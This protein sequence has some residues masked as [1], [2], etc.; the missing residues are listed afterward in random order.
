LAEPVSYRLPRTAVPE[1]YELTLSPDLASASFEGSARIRVRVHEP[2]TELV[3]NAIELDILEAAVVDSSGRRAEGRLTFDE[4]E[5]RV[6]VTTGQT[7]DPGLYDLEFRFNGILNDKLRGFYRST[8]K[9]EDGVEQVIATTQFEAT[10]ARRAFPCW[11]EPDFKATFAVTLVVDNSLTALSN[12]AIVKEEDAGG[13]KRRV[14]FAET[15]PMSTYLVAFVVGPFECTDPVE[16]D[17]VPLRVAA[18]PGH[19]RLTGFALEAGEAALRFLAGYFELPYPSDKLDH[20]AIPDFA[21]GAMEN[22]GCVTYRSTALL[23]DTEESSRLELQR[24]AVVVAHETAHMWFGDLVTMKW[25]NGIWLNEAFATLMEVLTTDHFRPEWQVWTSFGL[26][27]NAALAVDGLSSTRPI[28]FPVRQPK[29]AD[30]MFDV[31]TYQKGGAVLRMLEQH[32]GPDT[33]RR[34]IARYL[35]EH[36]YGNTETT[37]LWDA[38][39][40]VSGDPVRSTMDS[41]IFQG[42]YPLISVAAEEG[43]RRLRL[44]QERFLY[45]GGSSDER[46]QVP[47]G[48]RVSAGGKIEH[49][50]LLLT[51]EAASV[52]L[53]GPLD[54]V[55]ANDGA[56]GFYRTRYETALL[57]KLTHPLREHLDPLERVS[58]I[59]DTWAAVLSGHSDLADYLGLIKLLGDEEDPDV[60]AT[61]FG[62]LHLLDRIIGD[63]DRGLLETFV[64]RVVSPAFTGVGWDPVA[65]EADRTRTLR[66]R[67]IHALGTLGADPEVRAEAAR[68]HRAYLKDHH[69]LAPDLVSTAAMVVTRA[70]GEAE[71]EVMVGQFRNAATPQEEIRYLYTLGA[72]EEPE[73]IARTLE[74][75]LSGEVRTQDAPYLMGDMLGD[76]VAA[77]LTWTFIERHWDTITKRFPDNSIGR[78]LEGVAAVADPEL[79]PRAHRFLEGHPVPQAEKQVAQARERMDINVAFRRRVE[80]ELAPVLSSAT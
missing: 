1:Q 12:S 14:V 13:G 73:L 17:G 60:W 57:E 27:R 52:D 38:I 76:R 48:L 78:M 2:V 45:S 65:G 16:V 58:M 11:D 5:E 55:V 39:E 75:C 33:F 10:D 64:R 43:G 23:V 28:E 41:W 34:G 26:S 59:S 70:G 7:L 46:W 37:D 50:R 54:W 68:R 3:L 80:G 53:S 15:I 49:H 72:T 63:A 18:T 24:V 61:A 74:M 51:E 47:V 8:F 25:W 9:D 79:A 36:R 29:E 30:A 19:S 62:P 71:Y 22:L 32:L 31:L 21:F 77:A 44:T 4:P 42:G 35:S 56:W 6:A 40:A 67:L 20:V 66:A 69:A